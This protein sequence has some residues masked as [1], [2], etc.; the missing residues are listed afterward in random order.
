MYLYED[1][2]VL[3]RRSCLSLPPSIPQI[4][5]VDKINRGSEM[6]GNPPRYHPALST[7]FKELYLAQILIA[8]VYS[9]LYYFFLLGFS[10]C[11]VV[12]IA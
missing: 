4:L 10:N 6:D 1:G 5:S 11:G 12:V 3:H 8:T 2:V 9:T 7:P